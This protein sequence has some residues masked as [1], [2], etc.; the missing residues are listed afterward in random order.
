M[1]PRPH[2]TMQL[3]YRFSCSKSVYVYY[4]ILCKHFSTVIFQNTSVVTVFLFV[5]FDIISCFSCMLNFIFAAG[6]VYLTKYTGGL[7]QHNSQNKDSPVIR[8]FRKEIRV[9]HPVILHN[10]PY[11]TFRTALLRNC[12]LISACSISVPVLTLNLHLCHTK[13]QTFFD[14]A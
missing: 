12:V 7:Y 13:C 9:L 5:F 6:I 4:P 2:S 10:A 1:N 3:H 14:N 11:N 8:F